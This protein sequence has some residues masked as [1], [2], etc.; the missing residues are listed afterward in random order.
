MFAYK[1]LKQG[2]TNK[3]FLKSPYIKPIIATS[4]FV[5]P[6]A[7]LISNMAWKKPF[8][9]VIPQIKEMPPVEELNYEKT[10]LL[11]LALRVDKYDNSGNMSSI[12]SIWDMLD[13]FPLLNN[14]IYTKLVDNEVINYEYISAYITYSPSNY[15]LGI[16]YIEKKSQLRNIFLILRDHY[17]YPYSNKWTKLN[18]VYYMND[19]YERFDIKKENDADNYLSERD[20]KFIDSEYDRIVKKHIN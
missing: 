15:V 3:T 13:E 9:R 1:F 17:D 8:P 14:K 5:P 2:I 4:L 10:R 20:K 16:K 19:L 7:Y 18:V 12:I 6:T 11:K